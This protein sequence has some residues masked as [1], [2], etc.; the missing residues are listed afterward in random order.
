ML[1]VN[2]LS[3][4][5]SSITLMLTGGMQRS[6]AFIA[7]Y[8]ALLVDAATLSVSA[9]SAQWFIYSQVHAFG[10]LVFAATMNVRQV[11]SIIYSYIQYGH[12]ITVLQILGLVVIFGA[13]FYKSYEGFAA[14]KDKGETQPLTTDKTKQTA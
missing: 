11:V 9:V 7:E 8:P 1:Y 10:A 2:F 3:A 13:L 14:K 5:L 4:I 12:L 6:F